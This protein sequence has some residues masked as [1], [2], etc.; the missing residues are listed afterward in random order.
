M[1]KRI[2]LKTLAIATIASLS[3]TAWTADVFPSKVIK[4]VVLYAAGGT[5]DQMARILAPK[6]GTLLKQSV[7]VDNRVGAGTTIGAD[8]VLRSD[9]DGHTIFM[10]SNAAFTI[11]PQLLA[12]T[13]YDPLKNFAAIGTIASF[14]N[15]ILVKP[16]SPFKTLADV[17]D[18]AKKS[19]GS[20]SYA[21]FGIGSTAEIS[22]EAIKA[23]AKADI[24]EVPYK[25][26]AQ[27]VQAILSGEVSL[28][29]DTAVGSV[30]RVK[31]GQLRAI[32]VTSA[33]RYGE[34]PQVPSI[35]EAGFPSAEM[36]AWV[37]TFVPANTPVAAQKTLAA[38]QRRTANAR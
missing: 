21:S 23:A 5:I 17:V 32:A 1:H 19:P 20:L 24:T 11:S 25:S 13:P 28:G 33:K 35:T 37:A 36:V 38:R 34:L 31:S 2:A 30:S 29:F 14:P 16:D 8:H 26:G 6:L 7:M 22:G 9:P 18:A 15:L 27:C 12:K 4:I 10:G 3:T